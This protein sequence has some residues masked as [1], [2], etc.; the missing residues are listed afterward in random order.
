MAV[1][2]EQYMMVQKA[3]AVVEHPEQNSMNHVEVLEAAVVEHQQKN[4]IIHSEAV[5]VG[6]QILEPALWILSKV[7]SRRT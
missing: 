6:H 7:W 2:V 3:A 1:R 4:S 5:K